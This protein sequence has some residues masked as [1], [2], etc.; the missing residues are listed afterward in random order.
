MASDGECVLMTKIQIKHSNIMV[1]MVI[2]ACLSSDVI[3]LGDD[4]GL[5]L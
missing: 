5:A 2:W 4:Q 1:I 3:E